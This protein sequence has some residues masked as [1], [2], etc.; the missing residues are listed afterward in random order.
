MTAEEIIDMLDKGL[1]KPGDVLV[2]H[3]RS[4][5][6][7]VL[8]ASRLRLEAGDH[9]ETWIRR[10]A[11]PRGSI[12]A[13]LKSFGLHPEIYLSRPAAQGHIVP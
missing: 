12:H 13:P 10:K 9:S 8:D 3:M 1:L 7:V 11:I 4:I 6:F 2:D 5:R